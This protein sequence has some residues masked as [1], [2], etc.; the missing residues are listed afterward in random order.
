MQKDETMKIGIYGGTFN[1][2][3]LGHMAAAQYAA[4]YLELDKLF[5]IPAGLPPHKA[6]AEDTPDNCHRIAMTK[7]AAEAM[8][9]KTGSVE[10]SSWE[11]EREGKSYSVETVRM[12]RERYPD[13][14]IWFLMGTD[15]FLTLQTW[16]KAEELLQIC[17]ICAFGRSEEDSKEVFAAQREFLIENYHA[18]VETITLPN[19]VEVSST[20]IRESIKNGGGEEFLLPSVYGYILR[21]G[22]YGAR[23]DLHG[24]PMQ[25][26][27]CV[28]MSY[29][30]AK[31]IPHV[32][33]T[34]ETAARLARRY[35]A[36]EQQA[37]TA[38]LLHDCTKRLNMEEQLA[39]CE[40]YAIVLD[41]YERKELKLLHAKTGAAVARDVFGVSEE[42]CSAIWWHTTGKENMTLLEKIIYLADYIEPTRDFCDLCE[43]RRLADE[44]LDQA[45]LLGFTMAVEDLGR[46]GTVVHPNSVR[47]RDYLKG[48]LL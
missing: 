30:K 46:Q 25:K 42:V 27:R 37:R 2:I 32:L 34:E 21:H 12:F 14:E 33:G 45:L 19:L 7:L 4:D 26:L 18:S 31:R 48:T 5:L 23:D 40:K 17:K 47:A 8:K 41:E 15:M 36:D 39:L 28:A 44:D 29:L 1:P 3:H 43:L 16:H 11:L 22:L 13:D 20:D 38:A 9:L 35:G 10:V 6:L 24:L